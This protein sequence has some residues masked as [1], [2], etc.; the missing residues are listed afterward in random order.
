[1]KKTLLILL[2]LFTLT[3]ASC[4]PATEPT[5]T[6]DTYVSTYLPVDHDGAISVRNQLALG[7]LNL[8]GTALAPTS[9]EAQ[10]LLP[11]WQALRS[12][13]TSGASAPEEIN[14]I[15]AQIEAGMRPEQ[16]QEIAAMGLTNTDMQEWASANGIQTGSGGG[17]PGQGQGMS[18]EARA[19]RQAEEGI[20]SGSTGGSRMSTA[21]IDAVVGFLQN[22]TP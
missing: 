6:G 2:A 22:L 14:A 11:L 4:A 8:G 21:L 12:L 16:L 7:T 13:Q 18:P 15:L 20:T 3:L 1:M 5:T 10:A 17:V 9:A 19:T